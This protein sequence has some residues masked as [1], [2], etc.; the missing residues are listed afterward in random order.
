MADVHTSSPTRD[1]AK[2]LEGID[3]PANKQKLVE[4]ARSHGAN[5]DTI[6]QLN[7]M[8]DE[9]Y[10]SMADVFKGFGMKGEQK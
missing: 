7:G 2:N 6:K 3:F 1:L 8:P 4:W 10:T 5:E 9:E